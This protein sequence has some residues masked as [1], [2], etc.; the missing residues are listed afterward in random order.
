MSKVLVSD[1]IADKG[2]TLLEE[3]EFDVIYNPNPSGDELLSLV[4][5]INAWVVRSGTNI[6]SE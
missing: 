2:I 3:A 1:P 5:E 4:R 6:T